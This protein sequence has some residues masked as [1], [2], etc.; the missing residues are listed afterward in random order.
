MKYAKLNSCLFLKKQ[1]LYI[2]FSTESDA[3]I[4][5]SFQ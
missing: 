1:Y 3:S 5:I 4:F 2:Y